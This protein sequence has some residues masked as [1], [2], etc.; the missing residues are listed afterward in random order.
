MSYPRQIRNFNVFVDGISYFG[1]AVEAKLPDVKVNTQAYRGAG[2]EGPV[3]VDMGL[4]AMTA[5][6]TFHEWSVA[7]LAQLGRVGRLVLRPAAMGEADL[8]AD[9]IV[10]SI[11]GLWR[12]AEFGGLKAGEAASLKLVCDVRRF[13]LE[14]NAT[15]VYDIDLEI[16]KRV[17]DGVDQTAS[18]RRAM[19]L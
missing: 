2:M 14:H 1:L 18:L 8:T 10:A 13:K 5:E 9:A 7:L 6:V 15:T 12:S 3:G 19:G 16:G 4:E 17:V 11:S